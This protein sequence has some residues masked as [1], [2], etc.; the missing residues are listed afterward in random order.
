[1]SNPNAEKQFNLANGTYNVTVKDTAIGCDAQATLIVPNCGLNIDAVIEQPTYENQCTGIVKLASVPSNV[2]IEWDNHI[3]VEKLIGACPGLHKVSVTT[4]TGCTAEDSVYLPGQPKQGTICADNPISAQI[5]TQKDKKCFSDESFVDIQIKGGVARFDFQWTAVV[6]GRTTVYTSLSEDLENPLPGFY[7][8]KI[9]DSRPCSTTVNVT[10]D[11]PSSRLSS[12]VS[13]DPATCLGSLGSATILPS[14]GK[15]GYSITWPDLQTSTSRSNLPAGSYH[16]NVKDAAGCEAPVDFSLS[17]AIFSGKIYSS[18]KQLCPNDVATLTAKEVAGYGYKW[19]GPGMDGS[20][21]WT[22]KSV[23][24]RL[25]GTYTLQYT[26]SN[27]ACQTVFETFEITAGD[28][29]FC[30]P[31]LPCDSVALD[32]PPFDPNHSCMNQQFVAAEAYAEYK[33]NLYLEEQKR[34]F[35]KDYIQKTLADAKESLTMDYGEQEQHYTLY[36]YDQAGNLV[37]TVPPAGVNVLSDAQANQAALAMKDGS[38]APVFT[39]HN[40]ASTYT[41]NSLNQLVSQDIPD[42]SKQDLWETQV[43]LINTTGSK[44]DGV[45]YTSDGDGVLFTDN[46]D[47]SKFSTTPDFGKTWFGHDGIT[48]TDIS[49][50]QKISASSAFAVGKAGLF[51]SSNNG[52]DNWILRNPPSKANFI[53]VSFSSATNG[54]IMSETGVIWTT[55]NMGLSW[56]SPNN[57]FPNL[58]PGNIKD[59]WVDGAQLWITTDKGGQGHI[60]LS[61]NNNTTWTEQTSFQPAFLNSLVTNGSDVLAAGPL[62]ALFKIDASGKFTVD[63]RTNLSMPI[64]QLNILNGYLA[65]GQDNLLYAAD[66]TG[67]QWTPASSQVGISKVLSYSDKKIAVT[68]DGKV[69][70]TTSSVP[71][72]TNTFFAPNGITGIS[73]VLN[74][75][76]TNANP[77]L[78]GVSNGQGYVVLVGAKILYKQAQAD[79]NTTLGWT[80]VNVLQAPAPIKDIVVKSSSQWIVLTTTGALYSATTTSTSITLATTAIANNIQSLYQ[81]GTTLYALTT[82]GVIQT[83]NGST[84]VAST[85]PTLPLSPANLLDL[86]LGSPSVASFAG[87]NVYQLISGAWSLRNISP[88]ILKAIQTKD[89]DGYAAGG[90]GEI[91]RRNGTVWQYQPHIV[92]GTDFTDLSIKVDNSIKLASGPSIYDYTASIL[93]SEFTATGAITEIDVEG[94]RAVA[95]TADGKIYGKA[96][97][98]DAWTPLFSNQNINYAITAIDA[99]SSNNDIAAGVSNLTLVSNGTSWTTTSVNILPMSA[100]AFGDDEHVIAVGKQGTILTSSLRGEIWSSSYSFNT[101]DLFAVTAFGPT[102]A[103]AGGDNG[104]LLTTSDG[105]QSWT[106]AT[107]PTAANTLPVRAVRTANG[108]TVLAIAGNR[109]LKSTNKG[110][111]FADELVLAN[112]GYGLWLDADGYGMV[113]GDAGMAYRITPNGSN[114]T[115]TLLTTDATPDDDKGTGLP[116]AAFRSV[117]FTDRLTG[118]ITGTNGLV[119]KTVDGGQHWKKESAGTGTG[120]P[121]LSLADGKQGTLVNAD[122]SVSQLKDQAQKLSTRYW[123]DELGRTVLSQ[124]SKQFNIERYNTASQNNEVPGNGTVRAYGYM[125]YDEIGRVVESGE[126][127]SRDVLTTFKYETQIE[128]QKIKTNF[129]DPGIKR[130]ITRTYYDE[131]VFENIYSNFKQENLR[132]RVASITYQEQQGSTY[133]HGT[134]FSY[135]IHGNVKSLVQ[136]INSPTGNLLKKMDYEYDLLTGKVNRL[137][138]QGGKEDQF[139]HKYEYDGDNRIVKVLTSRDGILWEQDASYTYYGHGPMAKMEV[140]DQKI[141]VT[142]FAYTLQGWQKA[143]IGQNFSYGLGHYNNDYKAINNLQNGLLPTPVSKE[144]FNKNIATMT[145]NIPSFTDSPMLIQQFQYDQL[146]RIMSSSVNGTNANAYKTTYSYDPNGNMTALKRFDKV[147][148]PLDQLSYNYEKQSSGYLQ[149]TNKLRSVDESIIQTADNTDIEDQE[150]DNYSYDDIGNLEKDNQEEISQIR[151][152]LHHRIKS[153]AT[154]TNSSKPDLEFTYDATGNRSIKKAIQK[155]GETNLTYYIRDGFGNIRAIYEQ[156]ANNQ[157]NLTENNI[158]AGERISI[159]RTDAGSSGLSV[160]LDQYSRKLGLKDYE[161]SDHLGNVMAVVSNLRSTNGSVMLNEAFGYYPFGMLMPGRTI[162]LQ[163]YRYGFN[164]MEKDDEIK[165]VGKSYTSTFRQYDPRLCR[166]LGLDPRM[167]K[168][169]DFSPYNAFLNSPIYFSDPLGDDPSKGAWERLVNWGKKYRVAIDLWNKARKLTGEHLDTPSFPD[170]PAEHRQNPKISDTRTPGKSAG[171]PPPTPPKP[172]E[173]PLGNSVSKKIETEVA[174][175][176]AVDAEKLLAKKAGI[177]LSKYIPLVNIPIN[178]GI[179]VATAPKDRHPLVIA[180]RVLVSEIPYAGPVLLLDADVI[181]EDIK[182][183]GPPAEMTL[184]KLPPK[185]PFGLTVEQYNSIQKS[186]GNEPKAQPSV[187]ERNFSPAPVIDPRLQEAIDKQIKK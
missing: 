90:N 58:S 26:S 125:L 104:T 91:Y 19:T 42:H 61:S 6:N 55:T 103:V 111:S 173:L 17:P 153:V 178:I 137:I 132:P 124:N 81:V 56:S 183:I 71:T 28:S 30:R 53:K 110:G 38:Q 80:Q 165:G 176:A 155:S 133:E 97:N 94:I 143:A 60:W 100:V 89:T 135:D 113:V 48:I 149:N 166:W 82:S 151:W 108:N 181:E 21:K 13:I 167:Q 16:V 65:I 20:E 3:Q 180:T 39:D 158:Y 150:T 35:K 123:Y 114:F 37:R 10:V 130:E 34:N 88:A 57:T 177:G 102:M 140:G 179:E 18:H 50:V 12:S 157:I 11:G 162:Q 76:Q 185:I 159:A 168:Y 70:E 78:P 160:D 4:A 112:Q 54:M 43:P 147:G 116:V 8:L 96:S 41:Y 136:E 32:P 186:L 127:L 134:H 107:V 66:P 169:T 109:L 175:E 129:I 144:L 79:F 62:G 182:K 46:G 36:Y 98:V 148:A 142:D 139:I 74:I 152:D 163:N 68:S 29:L 52:G 51:L 86:T 1:L 14:G 119:I 25:V 83:L 63:R 120:T 172:K 126:L 27:N 131:V 85:F 117:Q 99:H 33:Y 145:T 170:I 44:V 161:L 146:N 72:W 9:T 128:S 15:P 156:G 77:I 64:K 59:V 73:P 40:Y 164:G 93:T 47:F 67:T 2:T 92:S 75:R 69:A 174:E 45:A 118:Y 187:I 95:A 105:G 154:T 24:T 122:G 31:S 87:G 115:Y 171:S 121:I 141:E 22:L 49:D 101:T 138:Y 106:K 5:A 84:L 7:T 184:I 23:Q